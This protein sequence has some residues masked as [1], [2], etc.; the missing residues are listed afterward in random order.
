MWKCYELKFGSFRKLNRT[1]YRTSSYTFRRNYSFLNLELVSL[2]LTPSIRSRAV[3][4]KRHFLSGTFDVIWCAPLGTI[5]CTTT[6]TTLRAYW[7]V[8]LLW[9]YLWHLLSWSALA[10]IFL[11]SN[12]IHNLGGQK[13]SCPSQNARNVCIKFSVGCMVSLAEMMVASISTAS[14]N[15]DKIDKYA[16][17]GRRKA[18][19]NLLWTA[20][21]KN[22]W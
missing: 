13:W 21:N 19:R 8:D 3:C 14:R 15:I 4:S 16:W 1:S 9:A 20:P 7:G 18:P 11:A 5:K 10:I 6:Y 22:W 17:P 12:S 2:G